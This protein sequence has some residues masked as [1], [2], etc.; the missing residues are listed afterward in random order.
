V[1][2]VTVTVRDTAGSSTSRVVNIALRPPP[3]GGSILPYLSA[4]GDQVIVVPNG[5]YTSG[6]LDAVTAPGIKHPATSGDLGGYLV[7]RAETPGGV[8]I[9]NVGSAAL[10]TF[11]MRNAERI[12]FLGFETEDVVTRHFGCRSVYWWYGE[13]SYPVERHP[14][15]PSNMALQG[16]T[17][18]CAFICGYSNGDSRD[19]RWYG[20]DVHDC[21]DDGFRVTNAYDL[22][23]QGCRWE[24][25]AHHN[26]PA[27]GAAFHNDCVQTMGNASLRVL[28]SYMRPLSAGENGS[29]AGCMF[30][31]ESGKRSITA[32]IRR[33][34]HHGPG[35]GKP[36]Q[37]HRR[38]T[39]EAGSTV[40]V[41]VE[42]V[43]AWNHA[44][45]SP[46]A[47]SGTGVT[48]TETNV[49]TTVPTGIDPATAWRNAHPYDAWRD[50]LNLGGTNG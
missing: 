39:A 44:P 31:I 11:E 3:S 46:I 23:W 29:D 43:H 50:V 20:R 32:E 36:L 5:T 17:T 16:N 45:G 7:L 18:P 30:I 15:Y 34:W 33:L 47:K 4:P 49:Q 37:F 13:S 24:H 28:D 8:K 19:L 48:V 42:D 22:L 21:G 9:T 41:V 2:D 14:D 38:D 27:S 35:W 25:I 40:N 1:P 6:V 12:V 10:R 26:K